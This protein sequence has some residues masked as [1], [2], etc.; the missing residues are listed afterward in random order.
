MV[1]RRAVQVTTEAFGG[2]SRA[3][4]ARA[5][6]AVLLIGVILLSLVRTSMHSLHVRPIVWG[7]AFVVGAVVLGL[8]LL[9][10]FVSPMVRAVLME[11]FSSLCHQIPGRSPHLHGVQLAICDRCLGI[12]LGGLAG[13]GL[14]PWGAHFWR[15]VRQQ[16]LLPLLLFLVPMGIDWMAPVLGL[17]ESVPMSRGITGGVAGA[18][19]AGFLVS[20]M[21]LEER[22]T[23]TPGR[24]G[25]S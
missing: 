10:P 4:L 25:E 22:R 14:G 16:H 23:R 17:W 13:V 9:P 5:V 6:C 15:W 12:Y 21:V 11:G 20:Q 1:W 18:G 8:A 2:P 7:G 19:G 24:S 3:L